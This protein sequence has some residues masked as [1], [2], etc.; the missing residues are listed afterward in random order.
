[1]QAISLC[2]AAVS[3]LLLGGCTQPR[4]EQPSSP[5]PVGEYFS[6]TDIHILISGLAAEVHQSAQEHNFDSVLFYSV[7]N[8]TSDRIDMTAFT[9]RLVTEVVNMGGVDVVNRRLRDEVRTELSRIRDEQFMRKRA[10]LAGAR[11]I[12]WGR[13]AQI[14]TDTGPNEMYRYYLLTVY[15]ADVESGVLISAHSR[16]LKKKLERTGIGL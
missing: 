14:V 4:Y 13:L 11:C 16:E 15:L 8:R 6:D 1:M 7:V 9:Q 5:T 10:R 3:L 2:L 12:V